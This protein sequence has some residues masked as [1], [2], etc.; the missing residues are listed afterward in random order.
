MHKCTF[1]HLSIADFLSKLVMMVLLSLAP[2]GYP[3]STD[4]HVGT[5]DRTS[6][7][8]YEVFGIAGAC[9]D[10]F[11]SVWAETTVVTP[12]QGRNARRKQE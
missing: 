2:K 1:H 6:L 7:T 11:V 4:S 10:E 8:S 9:E 12:R 5:V 3:K